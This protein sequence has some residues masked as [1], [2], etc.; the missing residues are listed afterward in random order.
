[1]ESW[2]QLAVVCSIILGAAFALDRRVTRVEEAVKYLSSEIKKL[3]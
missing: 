2:Y 3:G 1:M